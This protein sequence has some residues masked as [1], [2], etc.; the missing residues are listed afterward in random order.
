M[1]T[2]DFQPRTR[3]IFGDG[4]FAQLGMLARELEFKRALLVAD[5]GILSCGYVDEATQL[6]NQ[7]GVTAFRFHDFGENPDTAMVEA[8]RVVA[9]EHGVDSIIAL[10]G[11]SSL[12]T[13][14]GINFVLTNGG[15]MRDYW[16]HD[17]VSGNPAGNLMLPM[18]GVPTTAGTGS[19]AQTYALIS[20]A[21]THVKMACGDAQ[22]A[23]KITI[24]DPR[25]TL[26]QPTE[27]TATAGYD[28]IAHAVESFVTLNRNPLSDLFAKEAW[29]L[30]ATNYERVLV[31]PQNIE[32]R[33]AMLLGAHYA[34]IAIENSM[35]GA[36]HAC[37]NPLTMHYGTAHGIAIAVMLPHV[38]RWNTG[39]VGERYAEL[40]QVIGLT[41]AEQLAE[42]LA[43]LAH[44]GGLPSSLTALEIPHADLPTLATAASKQWTGTFNPRTFSAAG[45]K[46]LY[47][48]AY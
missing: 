31:E 36:T 8:G 30:L 23:F 38:V 34:G 35:L 32:A 7:A 39:T 20:D 42:R 26:T 5:R 40:A 29:R 22:A 1:Q 3:V 10:G 48:W 44:V 33:G 28:A 12:D 6:L 37:A 17:K 13:A 21:E 45:A 46:E 25:L 47:E 2:F 27:L 43:Q 14:K 41:F 16:G 11:G 4:T 15:T 9:A 18:I 24:L 19:E